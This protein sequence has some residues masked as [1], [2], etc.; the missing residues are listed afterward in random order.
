MAIPRVHMEFE[1]PPDVVL[2]CD[3]AKD[4]TSQEFKNECDI[5]QIMARFRVSGVVPGTA[6][7]GTYGDF[8]AVEDFQQAQAVIERARDQFEGLSADVRARFRNDPVEF[9]RFVSDSGNLEEAFK[10]G[11]LSE[12]YKAR[13]AAEEAAKAG[14]APKEGGK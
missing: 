7:V 1:P 2:D 4:M 3:A 14:G 12:E 11:L 5:N 6:R 13:R 8:S 9:L 10:L